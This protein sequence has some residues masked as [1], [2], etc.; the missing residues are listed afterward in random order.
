MTLGIR[1]IFAPT[2]T[3]PGAHRRPVWREQL[4]QLNRDATASDAW[5]R[6][7]ILTSALADERGHY[8]PTS[9]SYIHVPKKQGLP[10]KIKVFPPAAASGR[11]P[12]LM[13]A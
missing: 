5:H 11:A 7:H 2:A 6:P 13:L 12:R 1:R 10:E 4:K 8:I 3:V 9:R